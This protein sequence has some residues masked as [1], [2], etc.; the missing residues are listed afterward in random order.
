[1]A[2]MKTH[3]GAKGRV[4]VT[5]SGKVVGKRPGKR[6]LNHHKS[7]SEIRRKGRSFTFTDA[8]AERIKQLM[9]YA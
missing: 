3:K 2:K 8:E 7:G 5:G 6:H 9:P 1:M 4:K